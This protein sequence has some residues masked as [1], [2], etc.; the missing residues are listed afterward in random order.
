MNRTAAPPTTSADNA[1][2][3]ARFGRRGR[4]PR[5]D[6]FHEEWFPGELVLRDLET[7]GSDETA[8]VRAILLRF[9]A[10]R[11]FANVLRGDWP[12][13]LLRL[14]RN[15]A[16]NAF[17]RRP[18]LDRELRLL[19]G[20]LERC[21]GELRRPVARQLLRAA[22]TA[23]TRQHVA[24]ALALSQLGYEAAVAG[25]WWQEAAAA[26]AEIATCM[27]LQGGTR[28]QARWRRRSGALA[29]TARRTAE[30]S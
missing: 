19:R 27:G 2:L 25:R 24:G 30:G 7:V 5:H 8:S 4:R 1:D 28:A 3:P 11:Y 20:T 15:V 14:E 12:S 23:R 17:G 22:A 10:A 18:A 9:M 21:A 13:H 6:L 29:R 26:A 16:L